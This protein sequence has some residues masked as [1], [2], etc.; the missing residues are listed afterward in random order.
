MLENLWVYIILG[1]TSI[2]NIVIPISGSATVTPFLA[3]L[4][5]PHIA[6]GLA[7]FFFFLSGI[8]RVYMFRKQIQIKYVKSLLPI[9]LVAAIIGAFALVKIN[10]Q[11]LL[12]VILIFAS[13]FLYKKLKD[14]FF[15]KEKKSINRLTVHSIGFLSGFLQGTGLAGSD[16]RN[17]YLYSEK[18]SLAQV[19]GTTALI[20]ATNFFATT[21][22]RLST[23]QLTIPNLIPLLFVFPFIILGTWLGRKILYKIDK[24]YT[25]LIIILVMIL[26]VLFLFFKIISQ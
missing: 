3:I 12:I 7:S 23:N 4:T 2:I 8:V 15:Q 13:Y 22:I 9:S 1:L 25:N 5:T 19:H 21:I 26:I 17:N 20:G 10:P 24:K 14:V 16:L 11:I 18:L 6:I